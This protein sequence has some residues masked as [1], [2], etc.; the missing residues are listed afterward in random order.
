M[1]LRLQVEAGKFSPAWQIPWK[2][3]GLPPK[4]PS[5][6]LPPEPFELP[7]LRSENEGFSGQ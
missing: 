4:F 1:T 5:D 3:F 6:W 7:F 2:S